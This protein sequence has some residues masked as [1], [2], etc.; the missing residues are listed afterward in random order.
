M[1]RARY[2]HTTLALLTVSS[3]SDLRVPFNE[4]VLMLKILTLF[5]EFTATNS[6]SGETA[7]LLPAPLRLILLNALVESLRVVY[8]AQTG[9]G[10]VSATHMCEQRGEVV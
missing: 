8:G 1:G 6:E 3:L 4:P 7:T 2:E 9:G 10:G 5:F